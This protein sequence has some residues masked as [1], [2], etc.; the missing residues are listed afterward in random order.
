MFDLQNLIPRNSCVRAAA[1]TDVVAVVENAS[2]RCFEELR[3][4]MG[5]VSS[6]SIAEYM[7]NQSKVAFTFHDKEGHPQAAFS[8]GQIRPGIAE[9]SMI[10]TDFWENS[11]E[12]RKLKLESTRILRDFMTST[13][14]SRIF[15]RVELKSHNPK[16][17]I[18]KWFKF[19]GGIKEAELDA[20]GIDSSPF[21]LYAWTYKYLSNPKP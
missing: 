9:S 20:W 3:Q 6:M 11:R 5:K 21:F 10:V 12:G 7:V 17:E 18:Q 13:A 14:Q 15:R 2:A 4:C 1:F 19:L 16:E 8:L